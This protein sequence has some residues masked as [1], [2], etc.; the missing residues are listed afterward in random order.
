MNHYFEI[1][2]LKVGF[3]TFEGQ[4]RVLD[5]EH[6][7][8]QK[9]EAYGLIGESGSGKTVLA[10]TI[11]KLLTMPPAIV[12]SGKILFNGMDLITKSEHDMRLIRGKKISMI[13]Q[14]PMSTLNPVFTVGE[15]L[16]QVIQHNRGVAK[17]EAAKIALETIDLVKLPDAKSIID[18][19]PHELSGGQ[20]QRIIIAIA[21]SCGA[22]LLIADEPT[23][24]LDVTI[25]AGILKLIAE[26]QRELKVSVLFIANNPGLVSAVCNHVAILQEGKIVEKGTVRD[27]LR[28][29]IHPYTTALLN[30]IP[31]SKKEK[32]DLKKLIATDGAECNGG[33]TYYARCLK[34]QGNCQ[35]QSPTL[36]PIEGTHFVA[37]HLGLEG[38]EP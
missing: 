12:E 5:I 35:N 3:K 37:C 19:Y 30:T 27:V 34:R 21:L 13:F 36:H 11:L 14:D 18:K 15:Q 32:I 20:R 25:Q 6:L 2:D 17:K 26:L 9:G 10:L 4:K 24:N 23:R 29:P 31:K 1:K 33:C 38:S 7:A 22:E 16:R 8:I 28:N